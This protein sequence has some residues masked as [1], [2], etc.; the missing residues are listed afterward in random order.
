MFHAGHL[1]SGSATCLCQ[2]QA[3]RRETRASF[4]LRGVL[5]RHA[6]E[7]GGVHYN[8]VSPA[9]LVSGTN[10]L[11]AE[12][13]QQ[14][15]T[16][17]DLGFAFELTGTVTLAQAPKLQAT[18]AGSTLILTA[19]GDAAFFTLHSATNLTLPV[20]WTPDPSTAVLSNNQW[21]VTLPVGTNGQRFYRLQSR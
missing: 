12:V 18:L 1:T 16:S 6:E 11:A 19:P 3:P 2:R 5:V 15:L 14:A 8:T 21:R 7:P 13:H 4:G 9:F 10:L 17:S 20:V